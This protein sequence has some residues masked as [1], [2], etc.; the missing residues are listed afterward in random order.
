MK[1][2]TPHI[3]QL[4]FNE[5]KIHLTFVEVRFGYLYGNLLT[6]LVAL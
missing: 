1:F 6:Q 3:F 4:F 2:S 5:F